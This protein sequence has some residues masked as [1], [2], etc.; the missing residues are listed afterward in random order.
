M[1]NRYRMIIEPGGSGFR[2]DRSVKNLRFY[3][4]FFIFLMITINCGKENKARPENGFVNEFHH[5]LNQRQ[6]KI[7][8]CEHKC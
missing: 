5:S 1:E 6:V 7:S 8:Q 2:F 3:C 4:T